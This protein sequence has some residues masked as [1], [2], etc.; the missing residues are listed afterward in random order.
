MMT[1]V[2]RVVQPP[3]EGGARC[4]PRVQRR[5]CWG[6][7]RSEQLEDTPVSLALTA[8]NSHVSRVSRVR[9]QESRHVTMYVGP[10]SNCSLESGGPESRVVTRHSDI[11]SSVTRVKT[12]TNP[13]QSLTSEPLQISAPGH[14][15]LSPPPSV[16]QRSREVRC[17]GHQGESLALSACM[18]AT[19][20]TVVPSDRQSC[21]MSR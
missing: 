1:R 11:M 3:R 19:R 20:A 6:P 2:R 7:C 10:W 17:R 8:R 13:R 16:G 21:V 12:F 9:L 4:P 15:F 5:Q 18:D 14:T